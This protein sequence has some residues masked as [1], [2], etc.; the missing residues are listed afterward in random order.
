[1]QKNS[2]GVRRAPEKKKNHNAPVTQQ[3][4]TKVNVSI[5]YSKVGA[6]RRATTDQTRWTSSL[7]KVSNVTQNTTFIFI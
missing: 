7:K 1:M 3:S 5:L 2:Y 4:S 6:E